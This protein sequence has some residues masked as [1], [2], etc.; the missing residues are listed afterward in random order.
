M[1]RGA[2]RDCVLNDN[3]DVR[4]VK[5]RATL[6]KTSEKMSQ[7]SSS[8]EETSDVEKGQEARDEELA[9]NLVKNEEE[10]KWAMVCRPKVGEMVVGGGFL[11]VWRR[12]EPSVVPM[13]A[14]EAEAG[15]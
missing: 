12:M 5:P 8:G 15:T 14:V 6:K 3:R 4:S 11:G 1:I 7:S 13:G 9:E 10:E 2:A